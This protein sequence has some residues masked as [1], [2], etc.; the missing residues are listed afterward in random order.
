MILKKPYA[1]FI[2]NFKLFHFIIFALSAVLLYRTSLVY[3]FMKEYCKTNPNVIGKN[4]TSTLFSPW[5]YVL[6]AIILIVNIVIIYILIKKEKPYMYYII[7]ISLYIS[8]LVVYIVSNGI[9]HDMQE[10]L[11][12]AKT[13]LAIRDITNLARLFETISVIFYFVRSTG[14]DIKKFDFVRDL[15][16]LDISEE[17]S[18]EIEV[19]LEFE[20]NVAIRNIK[21]NLRNAK[22]YYKENKFIINIIILLTISAMCLLVYLSSNRYDKTYS[23]NDFFNAGTFTMGVKESNII[24]KDY[25]N[26]TIVPDENVLVAVKVGT[27]STIDSP[28]QTSRTIL[29]INGKRYYNDNSYKNNLIDLGNTYNG[30]TIT[31]ELSDYLLVYKI[32]KSDINSKMTFKYIDNI[33]YKRGKTI[34]NAFN[35]KLNPNKL[36]KDKAQEENY[37]LNNEIVINDYKINILNF[38]IQDKIVNTYNKCISNDKC[39]DLKEILVPS[40]GEKEKAILKIEG[41]FEYKENINNITNLYSFIEKYASIKYVHNGNEYIET[42]DFKEIQANKTKQNNVIYIEVDKEIINAEKISISFNLRNNIYTYILRGDT[43]E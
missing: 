4:L 28:L 38:Q 10:I 13:T 43:N 20:K 1:F 23:E 2:K 22:Y 27:K 16:G 36:D 14:F 19:A 25:R 39:I 37:K 41:T 34:V 30:E 24:T 32:P 42:N 15:Q 5:L 35:T 9:I 21:K 11:V 6:I 33:K 26:N 18:E 40:L 3:S 17:D 31:S 8:V 12:A 7:N 29:D